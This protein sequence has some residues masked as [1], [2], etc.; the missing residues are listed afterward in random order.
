MLC[1][2]LPSLPSLLK[3]MLLF[4]PVLSPE[5]SSGIPAQWGPYNWEPCLLF[6]PLPSISSPFHFFALLISSL[7]PPLSIWTAFFFYFLWEGLVHMKEQCWA[8]QFV[9]SLPKP[10]LSTCHSGFSQQHS[11]LTEVL[12]CIFA[13]HLFFSSGSWGETSRFLC[14]QLL[15]ELYRYICVWVYTVQICIYVYIIC[16]YIHCI[17][18]TYLLYVYILCVYI[19]CIYI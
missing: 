16:I 13:I 1:D 19:V 8:G 18:K 5:A 15:P 4:C 10:S 3:C 6:S 9:A 7:F 14:S 2:F 12:C 17:Y 11:R